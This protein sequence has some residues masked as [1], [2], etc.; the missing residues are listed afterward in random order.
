MRALSISVQLAAAGLL[1]L[2]SCT[3]DEMDRSV[4]GTE[5]DG[6]L[7]VAVNEPLPD[8]RVNGEVVVRGTA[9]HTQGL[10]VHSV[11]VG[12]RSATA[13]SFNFE[14]WEARVP[15]DAL[16]MSAD[17]RREIS[18]VATDTCGATSTSSR[19]VEL[20]VPA[21]DLQI[22][23][24]EYPGPSFAPAT[25][26][27]PVTLVA[28]ASPLSR[29]AVL[30]VTPPKGWVLVGATDGLVTLGGDGTGAARATLMLTCSEEAEE[31]DI[32][33]VQAGTLAPATRALRCAG[34]PRL[35]VTEPLVPGEST[36]VDVLT[37]GDVAGC[38]AAPRENVSVTS[39]NANLMASTSVTDSNG[40]EAPDIRITAAADAEP[41]TKVRI[42]CWD[43]YLQTV[44]RDLEIEAP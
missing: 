6:E 34:P 3:E 21:T 42:L 32:L 36:R 17:G 1:A 24:P 15:A 16:P 40:D 23:E 33:I 20:F 38:Q 11:L 13:T 9:T 26:P 39:G 29:G 8:A 18:V 14:T 10:A 37:D 44:T 5:D 30:K 28:T 41:G 4:C 12:G 27:V 2:A 19:V 31:T 25:K 43:S 35:S 22:S 7:E